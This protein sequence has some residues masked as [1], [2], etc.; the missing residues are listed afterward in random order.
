MVVLI[1]T[2]ILFFGLF[3]MGVVL[4]RKI[5]ALTQLP[6]V[7]GGFDFGVKILKLGEKIKS[8]IKL[9]P[10]E[11]FIQKILSKI[12]VLT[13]KIENKTASLLAQLRT[14]SQKKEENDKYW[15]KLKKSIDKDKEENNKNNLPR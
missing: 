1:A 7:S 12:R 2:I 3:G 15:Q 6:E 10:R 14:K 11:I 13:L 5:P 4:F 8:S 9:P